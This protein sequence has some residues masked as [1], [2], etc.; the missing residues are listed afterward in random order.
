M[1]QISYSVAI[2][3]AGLSIQPPPV[4]R[5]GN[6]GI[7]SQP[8]L[9]A[10]TG[11]GQLTTRTSNT[12]GIIT[13]ASHTFL[14]GDKVDVYWTGG[15]A[16]GANVDAKDATTITISGLAGTVLPALNTTGLV[17]TKQ[18]SVS[19]AIVYTL[20]QFLSLLFSFTSQAS[21]AKARSRSKTA[22]APC[23]RTS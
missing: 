13:F 16:Y 18:V 2:Q 1:P 12:A 20:L 9:P 22:A 5:S 10:G 14:V 15:Q 19:I 21:R 8:P 7:G 23:W 3:G 17:V 11:G 4:L 6:T